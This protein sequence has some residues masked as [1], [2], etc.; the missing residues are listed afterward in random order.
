MEFESTESSRWQPYPS[1]SRLDE[2]TRNLKGILN[3]QSVSGDDVFP[4]GKAVNQHDARE[5]LAYYRITS[6]LHVSIH[7]AFLRN[8]GDQND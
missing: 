3:K 8:N 7:G 4:I 5:W 6:S 2:K 1:I